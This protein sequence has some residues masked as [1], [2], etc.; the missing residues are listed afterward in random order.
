MEEFIKLFAES[1]K[2]LQDK[3]NKTS[4]S[5][6]VN[7]PI[8]DP[9]AD[10]HN[11]KKWCFEIEKLGA[12]FD[13]T[14]YELVM[15]SASGLRD[16]AAEWFSTWQPDEKTWEGLKQELCSIY[17]SKR[18]LSEKLRKASLFTSDQ[19]TSYC[20]YA[21]KKLSLLKSL[22]FDLTESQYLEIIIGDI[23]EV[24][25]K[26]AAFN[27]KIDNVSDLLDLL[28]NYKKHNQKLDS[29]RPK[30]KYPDDLGFERKS[31]KSCYNCHETGHISRFCP[32]RTKIGHSVSIDNIRSKFS[33]KGKLTCSFCHKIGHK[34]EDCF[35]RKREQPS[36]SRQ[37][38]FFCVTL[39]NNFCTQFK[40]QDVFVNCLIDTGAECSLISEKVVKQLNCHLE[41]TF[42]TLNG[43]GEASLF[44]NTKT[45]LNIERDGTAFEILFYVV[46]SSAITPDCILGRDLFIHQGI[47]IQAD[48][49]GTCIFLKDGN[50]GLLPKVINTVSLSA[51]VVKT[52]IQG[53][54][55]NDLLDLLAKYDQFITTGNSVSPISTA[56][57][58]IKLKEDKIINFHPYRMAH[59]E[60]EKVKLI[61]KDLLENNI[62]R[63]S[64]SPFASPIVLVHKKDGS[65]R[66]CCDFRAINKITV[67]DRY[68]L[69]RIE[70]QLDR[71]GK[72][73]YF[74][75]LDMA[76]GFHQI[77]IAECS[78]EKTAFVTPDGHYEYLRMPFGLSN[79]P[80]VFQRAIC[81]ALGDLK[82][83]DAMVYLDDILIPSMTI[84]EGLEKL[85]RVLD[86]L[87]KAGFSLN[88][89][90][91]N[92]FVKQI[93]YLGQEIS[94]GGIRPGK[95]KV[96][97]L[98]RAPDPRNVKQVRQFMGLANYFRKFIPEMASR[99][100]CIT[101]LT[102]NNEVFNWGDD[103]VEAKAYVCAFLS[104]RPL[105]AVFDPELETELHTDAS[106][107][108]Y[109]GILFQKHNNQLRVIAY[110]S[111]RTSNEE[112]KYHSYELETL[113]VFYAI[114]HFRVYLLGIK[115][116]IITDCNSLKL[117]QNKK[118]LIPRVARW[119]LF[120]QSFDFEIEYRKGKYI[121]HVDYFS[122]NPVEKV[123][124]PEVVR[125]QT[126]TTDNWLKRAQKKDQETQNII[127]N[128]NDGKLTTE[129]FCQNGLLFRK[130]NPGENPPIYRAFIPKGSRLGLLRLFHDEQCHIGPEKTFAKINHYFWFPGMAKFVRKYCNHCLKC[131]VSKNHTGPKQAHLHPIDKRPIPFHTVHADCV[132]PFPASAEG[133]KYLL[134]L[135]D[136]FTKFLFLAP[137]KG[138][139]GTETRDAM[140]LY[141]NMFGIT[142]R[143]I[144][145]RGTN[146][147]DKLVKT[148][149]SELG[150]Q[151]HLI[152]KSAPRG[153]G[154]VERY[155]GTVLNL[156]RTQISDKTEW[157]NVIQKLQTTLNTTVQK[158]TGFSPVY[159][160]TGVEGNSADIKSLTEC[161]ALTNNVPNNLINDRNLAYERMV[162]QADMSKNLFDKKRRS[163][164]VFAIGDY[165]YHPSGNSHLSKLDDRYEGP[166]E[167]TQLLPNERY[168]LKNLASNRKRVV[169]KD[170]IRLWPDDI[171]N[172]LGNLIYFGVWP[173]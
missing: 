1:V 20:E 157:P 72:N 70:D 79:A 101:K 80:A 167:I 166:F 12:A 114:K 151:Q 47:Q 45:N 144:C 9:R 173:F 148:L 99:T 36:T 33:D 93:E 149:L 73:K 100:A 138:L 133:Y 137:L 95:S 168:E 15:R 81:G 58:K 152:A 147:T 89:T 2:S 29:N 67:K 5:T 112:S 35:R 28:G 59:S 150:I 146:F 32:K 41:P 3:T 153:N 143:L 127:S 121:Q 87:T 65:I 76:S 18:N 126:V 116:K 57:L 40:I 10:D 124:A 55:L 46:S 63:E 26:T 165:V 104:K 54:D 107:I 102:K 53:Q 155:V 6:S 86:C 37:V 4:V 38:N 111:K 141:L 24:Q 142:K 122:R 8:F 118:E 135:V 90:K 139:S 23:N 77:P 14:D 31:D 172:D 115:F 92:F 13:W 82:D 48:D 160:L 51:E 75:T 110:F 132:G 11:A 62:I 88:I 140:A 129:Y 91:C 108:G 162:K 50:N 158:T 105:L 106:S 44:V 16:E 164:K 171:S 56:E 21:R 34:V 161:I 27:S 136:A 83:K 84:P 78:I 66:M 119:W 69:P 125:V 130:I 97:A 131:I 43:I 22:N 39:D 64:N 145:D 123:D 19:A 71:L 49:K 120:L 60:R 52:P 42:V 85:T 134:L 25:V 96:E 68:P 156:L 74:T 113:A 128:L 17:P 169:A 154:Q 61:I 163:N 30:R 103:Q 117:S 7:I 98:L 109:G 94:E 170:M 159:L